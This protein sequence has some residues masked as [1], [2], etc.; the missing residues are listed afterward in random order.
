M[1]KKEDWERIGGYDE[2]MRTGFEDWEFYIRI[3]KEGG[4]AK[5]LPDVLFN[6]RRR[7]ISTTSIAN[8]YKYKLLNYIYTKHK[9]LYIEN[10]EP[11]VSHLLKIAEREENEK[12]KNTQRVEFKIGKALLKPLRFIKALIK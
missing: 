5:V 9:D 2:T 11:F 10:Y 3:L 7:S 8:K 6:Y 12:L 4:Y 1:F